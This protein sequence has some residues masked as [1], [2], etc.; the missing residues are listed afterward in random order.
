MEA[1]RGK[2]PQAA[3]ARRSCERQFVAVDE[4]LSPFHELTFAAT[5]LNGFAV[6]NPRNA[7]KIRSRMTPA[8]PSPNKSERL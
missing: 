7:W 6:D 5:R 1:R 3:D 8:S 4:N 2:P